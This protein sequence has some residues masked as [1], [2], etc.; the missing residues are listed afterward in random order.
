MGCVKAMEILSAHFGEY[1]AALGQGG[2]DYLYR[3]YGHL[4]DTMIAENRVSE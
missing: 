3:V 4:V 1:R 2:K